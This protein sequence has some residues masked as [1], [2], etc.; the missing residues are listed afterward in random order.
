[1]R[2]S[3]T[4]HYLDHIR[5]SDKVLFP[6]FIKCAIQCLV[7][8]KGNFFWLLC[9]NKCPYTFI[10]PSPGYRT[11]VHGNNFPSPVGLW[12]TGVDAIQIFASLIDLGK[13]GFYHNNTFP[14]WHFCVKIERT[15]MLF[16]FPRTVKLNP[17]AQYQRVP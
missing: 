3:G 4:Y 10:K 11:P 1:M 15:C 14:R 5:S 6:L 8:L 12:L 7:K 9:L 13:I 2:L 17:L 16:V